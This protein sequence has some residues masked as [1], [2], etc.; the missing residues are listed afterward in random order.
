MRKLV[1]NDMK[2]YHARMMTRIVGLRLGLDRKLDLKARIVHKF[3]L[4]V[5]DKK[6]ELQCLGGDYF[7]LDLSGPSRKS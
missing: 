4:T 3:S 1:E 2:P 7:E 6:R 5:Y